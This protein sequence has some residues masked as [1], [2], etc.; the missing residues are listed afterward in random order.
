[1][2]FFIA[3]FEIV[4]RRTCHND[5]DFNIAWKVHNGLLLL[6]ILSFGQLVW[7][8]NICLLTNPNLLVFNLKFDIKSDLDN[9][10]VPLLGL[11]KYFFNI[12]ELNHLCGLNQKTFE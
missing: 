6:C 8:I 1:M 12:V 5:F 3:L 2:H 11:Q 4:H 7:I 9:L 10:I